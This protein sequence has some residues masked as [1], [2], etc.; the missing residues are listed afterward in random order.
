MR[1]AVV[2]SNVRV[3]LR[4]TNVLKRTQRLACLLIFCAAAVPAG[5]AEVGPA[6]EAAVAAVDARRAEIIELSDR[7]WEYAEI[8]LHETRSAALL[9]DFLEANG[10]HV[11]RGV[12]S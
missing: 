11:E 6:K 10:F 5:A 7:V 9:A 12:A 8:A 2:A 4:R 1:E 3:F